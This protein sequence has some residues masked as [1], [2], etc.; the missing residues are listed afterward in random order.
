MSSSIGQQLDAVVRRLERRRRATACCCIFAVVSCATIVL[1]G[2]DWRLGAWRLPERVALTA[3]LIV[4]VGIA[5]RHS[6]RRLGQRFTPLAVALALEDRYPEHRSLL[7]S[8][9]EF[10]GQDD[11]DPIAGSAELRRAVVLRAA[12]AAESMDL[13]AIVDRE[14]LRRAA[15]KAVAAAMLLVVSAVVAPRELAVGVTRLANPFS[16]VEFPRKHHLEFVDLPAIAPTGHDVASTLIDRRGSLPAIVEV[17]LRTWREGRWHYAKQEYVAGEANHVEIRWPNVVQMIEVR[18]VGGDHR[19]MPWHRIRVATA[20]QI[21][22]LAVVVQP[23][24]YTALPAVVAAEAVEVLAGSRVAVSGRVDAPIISGVLQPEQS[25]ELAQTLTVAD[26]G[27]SFEM[28]ST[29]WV[30]QAS[31]EWS[32]RFTTAEGM[33]ATAQRRLHID[34]RN[35]APPTVDVTQPTESLAVLPESVVDFTIRA[36]D[37]VAVAGVELIVPSTQ[38]GGGTAT[39]PDGVVVYRGDRVPS[40]GPVVAEHTLAISKLSLPIG[41][42]VSITAQASD[43]AGHVGRSVRPVQLRIISADEFLQRIDERME[44]LSETLRQAA[45]DQRAAMQQL[46]LWQE[47]Q[48]SRSTEDEDRTLTERQLRV[49]EAIAGERSSALQLSHEVLAEYERNRWS[50]VDAAARLDVI[51]QSLQNL[52]AGELQA[53]ETGLSGFDRHLNTANSGPSL[54]AEQRQVLSNVHNS[55]RHVAES[56]ERML[57]DLARWSGVQQFKRDMTRIQRDQAALQAQTSGLARQSLAVPGTQT[58]QNIDR[59]T[60]QV[61]DR[62]RDLASQ[63]GAVLDGA[64]QASESLAESQPEDA[65]RLAAAAKQADQGR[66]QVEARA[67]AEQIAARRFGQ[68]TASQRRA[69]DAIQNAIDQMGQG[70]G[71]L[72]RLDA[73]LK[74]LVAAQGEAV[75][76]VRRLEAASDSHGSDDVGRDLY[77][78]SQQ[79]AAIRDRSLATAQEIPM[80]PVFTR[81][82]IAAADTMDGAAKQLDAGEA[83][84]EAAALTSKAHDQLRRLA[85]AVHEQGKQ[86]LA[87]SPSGLNKNGGGQ[88]QPTVSREQLQE[89][90][91]ALAQVGLLRSKQ[92]DLRERTVALERDFAAAR[93]SEAERSEHSAALAAEQ[94]ELA[95]MADELRKAAAALPADVTENRED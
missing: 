7:S 65:A 4:A 73:A 86:R 33:A 50:D 92:A 67:A 79:Q 46:V 2:A 12:I 8:G 63:L 30:P 69:S 36:D 48:D 85:E 1:I 26:D 51:R 44:Q 21:E 25:D 78:A 20:P 77:G 3:L 19:T 28:A 75:V 95:S 11:C 57:V 68:A 31:G 14:P 42:R 23:P 72:D 74:A 83:I 70:A 56:L 81:L 52:A 93:L 53:I 39:A 66:A 76:E 89:M 6:R 84:E 58:Q 9:V 43:Y 32:L 37:D 91:L 38:L 64:R 60:Q 22:S 80:F 54:G 10:N 17:Y 29:G 55:Q 27:R 13:Y 94:E 59:Q 24:A 47:R 71:P 18:A 87:P 5:W 62:Q 40:T 41:S 82:L 15:G 16:D 35:D 34:V 45:E 49:R 90:Q 88:G 61:A